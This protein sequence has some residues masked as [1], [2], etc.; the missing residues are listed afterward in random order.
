MLHTNPNSATIG[1]KIPWITNWNN[2]VSSTSSSPDWNLRKHEVFWISPKLESLRISPTESLA[3]VKIS[4][5]STLD[6][7]TTIT[8]NIFNL[9]STV[10]VANYQD[11]KLITYCFNNTTQF[12]CCYHLLNFIL[13]E[14]VLMATQ[15]QNCQL[16]K[17][18]KSAT[19]LIFSNII[20]FFEKSKQ[21]I[22][23]TLIKP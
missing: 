4:I 1:R 14:N 2:L 15:F 21:W 12:L 9:V 19:I 11:R 18:F 16:I 5:I 7:L 22:I 17:F 13:C 3:M 23:C 8:L 10:D 6:I 20:I